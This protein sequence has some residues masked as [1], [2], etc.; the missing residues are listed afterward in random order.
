MTGGQIHKR[1]NLAG[2][3]LL[4]ISC[5]TASNQL[6]LISLIPIHL[7]CCCHEC[8]EVQMSRR[9]VS[10]RVNTRNTASIH[11][12]SGWGGPVGPWKSLPHIG[13]ITQQKPPLE[14]TH[15]SPRYGSPHWGVEESFQRHSPPP[16]LPHV[17][18]SVLLTWRGNVW[19]MEWTVPNT[20]NPLRSCLITP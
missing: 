19:S 10:P 1:Q 11:I 5:K 15:L 8:S 9:P 6:P 17:N 20:F 2:G 4:S 18:D 3:I 13:I 7:P 12:R 14:S 16:P